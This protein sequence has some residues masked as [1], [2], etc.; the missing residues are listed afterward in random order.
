MLCLLQ[1]DTTEPGAY[2]EKLAR[3]LEMH[4]LY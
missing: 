2:V 4:G 3:Q 1:I